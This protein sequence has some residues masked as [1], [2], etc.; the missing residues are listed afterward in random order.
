MYTPLDCA[1]KFVG[2]SQRLKVTYRLKV[3]N[4][5]TG[6]FEASVC[7]ESF[8]HFLL[9]YCSTEIH[10]ANEQSG[11]LIIFFHSATLQDVSQNLT[12]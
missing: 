12:L 6:G 8:Y 1:E 7:T 3:V 11:T 2:K 10:F 9:S 4:Y 5:A